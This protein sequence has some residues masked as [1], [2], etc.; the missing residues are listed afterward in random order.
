MY[1]RNNE[2]RKLI[3]DTDLTDFIKQ[4]LAFQINV[5]YSSEQMPLIERFQI[6]LLFTI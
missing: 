1:I 2:T 6:N 4:I 5:S 3:G